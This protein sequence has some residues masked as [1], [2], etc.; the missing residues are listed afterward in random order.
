MSK[1]AQF[2]KGSDIHFGIFE[3]RN[4]IIAIYPDFSEAE[5]AEKLVHY[6]GISPDEAISVSGDDVV[7]FAEE[8]VIKHGLW[9]V[10]MKKVSD[11]FATEEVYAERDLEMARR[12]AGFVA[13]HCPTEMV[14]KSVWKVLEPTSP[15]IARYYSLGGVEHLKGE[16]EHRAE[17][18]KPNPPLPQ[19]V[20]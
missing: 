20:R 18:D 17:P 7:R 16:N 10:L 19:E 2:F 4:H 1:L 6:S 13:V 15:L 11:F 12:G 5:N 14:K 8:H 3:P 9:G